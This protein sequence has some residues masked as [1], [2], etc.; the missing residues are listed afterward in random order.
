MTVRVRNSMEVVATDDRTG[1]VVAR[2]NRGDFG[3]DWFI[4]RI[5][6]GKMTQIATVSGHA[7]EVMQRKL[8]LAILKE[9]S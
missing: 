9:V 1:T 6:Y 4:G 8:V 2:A 3:K 7:P 5:I